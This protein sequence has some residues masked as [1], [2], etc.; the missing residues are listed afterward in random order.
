LTLWTEITPPSGMTIEEVGKIIEGIAQTKGRQHQKIAYL[1]SEDI[2]QE[3]R[4]KCIKSLPRY[5]PRLSGAKLGTFLTVCAE[6]RI[7]DIRRSLLYKHN[8]PC[9]RCPM[10]DQDAYKRGE[11]DCVAF[12]N[13][14]ACGK[15]ARHERYVQV[16]LSANHPISIDEARIEDAPQDANSFDDDF[17]RFIYSNLPEHLHALFKE[18]EISNF[19]MKSL[20]PKARSMLQEALKEILKGYER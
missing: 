17:I 3:V 7:R 18:L 2:A 5:D 11:H 19:E 9:F 20:K 4:I 1:D 10:W 15:F 16:K 8:K 12:R 6:N 14:M 13:K